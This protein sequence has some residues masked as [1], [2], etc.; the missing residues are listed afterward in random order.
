MIGQIFINDNGRFQ[1]D[2]RELTSGDALTVLI[3]DGDGKP[4]WI[5]TTVE[6]NE[7]GYYLTGLRCYSFTGLFAA[8]K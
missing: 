1:V 5:D 3:V 4:K 6:H 2:R 8:V 7:G